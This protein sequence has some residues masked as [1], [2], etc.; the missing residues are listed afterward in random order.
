MP[1]R[2]PRRFGL[3]TKNPSY[4]L[5]KQV[6]LINIT[7]FTSVISDDISLQLGVN[8][9]NFGLQNIL[10]THEDCSHGSNTGYLLTPGASVFIE[11]KNLNKIK[12]VNQSL[13]GSVSVEV[14]AI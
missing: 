12:A 3:V 5:L 8:I 10:V 14:V 6:T 9:L 7:E 4:K 2:I 11:A 13:E 1:S